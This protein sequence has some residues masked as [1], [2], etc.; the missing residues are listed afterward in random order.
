VL[1]Y[2]MRSGGAL[3]DVDFM[4]QPPGRKARDC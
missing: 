4:C 3:P 2:R 1:R